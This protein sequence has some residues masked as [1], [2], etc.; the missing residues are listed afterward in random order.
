MYTHVTV[1]KKIAAKVAVERERA[2]EVISS[3]IKAR[4]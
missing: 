3:I 4:K 2:K 1:F